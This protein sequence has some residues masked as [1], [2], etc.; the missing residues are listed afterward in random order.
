MTESSWPPW[1]A[2]RMPV[3][4]AVASAVRSISPRCC[5]R[6]IP[7]VMYDPQLRNAALIR[8]R[9]GSERSDS[10]VAS[11][12]I[13]QRSAPCRSSTNRTTASR[14]RRKPCG[15]LSCSRCDLHCE[16]PRKFNRTSGGRIGR[17][18]ALTTPSEGPTDHAATAQ[19]RLDLCRCPAGDAETSPQLV[20]AATTIRTR[21]AG[22]RP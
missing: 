21:K 6:N 15:E 19:V 12:P 1:W 7:A 14:R 8:I 4:R 16:F 13:G 22:I 10:S 18:P 2:A 9:A 20:G 11:E 17:L 3:A 5:I